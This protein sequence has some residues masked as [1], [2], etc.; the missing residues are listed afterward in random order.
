M[1]DLIIQAIALLNN[2]GFEFAI[3]GGFAIDL[4]LNEE[5]RTHGDIDILAYWNERDIII[6]FMQSKGWQV[7]ELCGGGKAHHITN[8]KQQFC[9]KRNIF[10]IKSGCSLV[11]LKFADEK[12]MYWVDFSHIGQKKLDFIEFLFNDKEDGYFLYARNKNI[13]RELSEAILF[14]DGVKY[15]APEIVLLYKSTDI[16]REGYQADFNYAIT[17]MSMPQKLWLLDALNIM[18]P[19]GHEWLCLL[20]QMNIA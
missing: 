19:D 1:N 16:K 3:C 14:K 6:E 4:F 17:K 13:T 20:K 10:C 8:V 7:Y 9:Y 15:L 12:D 5:T 11:E 2:N 18:F